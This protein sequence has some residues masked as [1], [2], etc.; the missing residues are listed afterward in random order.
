[1]IDK[2]HEHPVTKRFL[3]WSMAAYGPYDCTI[4]CIEAFPMDVYHVV[5]E[6]KRCGVVTRSQ[7]TSADLPWLGIDLRDK[8]KWKRSYRGDYRPIINR[9]G[10]S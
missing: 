5:T 4:M 2:C 3:W 6:C 8:Q 10:A 9:E 1:M 7:V